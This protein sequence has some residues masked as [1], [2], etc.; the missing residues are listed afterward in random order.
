VHIGSQ[1][2]EPAPYKRALR[3]VLEVV[4]LLR[5]EGI[6]LKYLDMGGGFGVPYTGEEMEIQALA[7]AVLPLVKTT[8]LRLVLEPGRS[9]VGEAGVLVTRVQAVK[10]SGSRTFVITDAGMTELIRPSHYGGFH[11]V[12]PVELRE[13]REVRRVDIVGPICETGDFLAQDRELPLPRAGELLAIGIAGAYGFT[14]ASNYNARPR[15]P[16]A[17]VDSGRVHLVR[18]RESY[19]DLVRGEVIP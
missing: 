1:I 15:P 8:R 2:V 7:D 18:R 16:E 5:K 3:S 14:M 11:P 4:H 13:D 12:Q 9:I 6:H 17:M 19:E 10:V